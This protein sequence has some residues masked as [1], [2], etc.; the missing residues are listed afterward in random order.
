MSNRI[1]AL[2]IW[3]WYLPP[4]RLL[5]N[6]PALLAMLLTF[7]GLRLAKVRAAAL[8]ASGGS[9][10]AA[11]ARYFAANTVF[12]QNRDGDARAELEALRA[13]VPPQYI[14]LHAQVGHAGE[15][16]GAVP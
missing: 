3:R 1:V 11:V 13:D 16:L 5:M 6:C 15:Q 8:F 12:D 4:V 2:V 9:P 10:M 7:S 14:A